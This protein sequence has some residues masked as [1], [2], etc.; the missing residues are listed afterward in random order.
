[1]ARIKIS[2]LIKMLQA[3]EDD[4]PEKKDTML[5]NMLKSDKVLNELKGLREDIGGL[6]HVVPSAGGTVESC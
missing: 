4:E 5:S 3:I 6:P 2:A 1:M